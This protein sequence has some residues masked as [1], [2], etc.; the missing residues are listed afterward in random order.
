M[1]RSDYVES[2]RSSRRN[3][4][5]SH[6]IPPPAPE[7]EWFQPVGEEPHSPP[8]QTR[9]TTVRRTVVGDRDW[10]NEDEEIPP[11][12][13]ESRTS[14]SSYHPSRPLGRRSEHRR[15]RSTPSR[16]VASSRTSVHTL[17]P[18]RTSMSRPSDYRRPTVSLRD[19]SSAGYEDD[20]SRD[21]NR[22]QSRPRSHIV[23][24]PL[25]RRTSRTFEPHSQS[26]SYT[27]DESD[28]SFDSQEEEDRA[29]R[30]RAEHRLIPVNRAE[31]SRSRYD[32]AR[33]SDRQYRRRGNP[34]RPV[35]E[36]FD[37]TDSRQTPSLHEAPPPRTPSRSRSRSRAVSVRRIQQ[38]Q[39][40]DH[41]YERDE[42]IDDDASAEEDATHDLHERFDR[43]TGSHKN[44][45]S[46]TREHRRA[47][48]EMLVK[49]SP[50]SKRYVS[51]VMI[52]GVNPGSSRRVRSS[53]KRYYETE[54]V[55]VEKH[56]RPRPSSA[57]V[58]RPNTVHGSVAASQHQSVSS[59]T[60]RP[61]P[62]FFERL[63]GPP[64]P[65]HR[66]Y[67]PEKPKKL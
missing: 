29:P 53:P 36:D 22:S 3:R 56:V 34:A 30:S 28:T 8:R 27:A 39:L 61:S 51:S 55:E 20:R 47:K 46:R 4:K 21:R 33:R 50:P 17:Q 5:N 42:N 23:S 64:L 60:K 18:P 35:H 49:H 48:S 52:S 41:V 15:D 32:A 37:D 9:R 13:P 7:V 1:A 31:R 14:S 2:P 57:S 26:E 66:H 54:V 65:K 59:S 45:R 63:L 62:N 25:S 43:P 19:G 16:S 44:R 67:A 6:P 58:R 38:R 24:T 12:T 11:R 40:E 10:D